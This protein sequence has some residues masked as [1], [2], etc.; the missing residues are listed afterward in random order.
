MTPQ[1]PEQHRACLV[2]VTFGQILFPTRFLRWMYTRKINRGSTLL[3]CQLEILRRQRTRSFQPASHGKAI[4]YH[5]TSCCFM[6]MRCMDG[7][8]REM[9]ITSP[10][11]LVVFG[12]FH[13]LVVY[14]LNQAS[15]I[16]VQDHLAI[17]SFIILPV[18]HM[19]LS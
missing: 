18:K 19:F 16:M 15:I 6:D 14:T 13:S 7:S 4:A 12:G 1:R 10:Y 17:K 3:A 2:M 8:Y 11:M 5:F 9:H